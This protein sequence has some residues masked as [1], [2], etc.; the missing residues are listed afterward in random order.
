V[1]WLVRRQLRAAV[2][3]RVLSRIAAFMGPFLIGS[4]RVENRVS[5]DGYRRLV[6]PNSMI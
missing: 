6:P 1:G 3:T 5:L 2:V 4:G